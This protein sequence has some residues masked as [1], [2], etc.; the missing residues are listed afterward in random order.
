MHEK[1]QYPYGTRGYVLTEQFNWS[2]AQK[3][4]RSGTVG[5]EEESK[6]KEWWCRLSLLIKDLEWNAKD[7]VFCF[8]VSRSH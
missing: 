3:Q 4:S 8:I 1:S 7:N 6:V 2:K 5:G